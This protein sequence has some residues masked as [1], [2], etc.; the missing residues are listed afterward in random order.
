MTFFM[1][2]A[3]AHVTRNVV[4]ST[5]PSFRFSGRVWEQDEVWVCGLDVRQAKESAWT[6]YT[7]GC[8]PL[9][10]KFVV[11]Y[12]N[13]NFTLGIGMSFLLPRGLGT[14]LRAYALLHR[15]CVTVYFQQCNHAKCVLS[16][17]EDGEDLQDP[18]LVIGV[19]VAAVGLHALH[20]DAGVLGSTGEY[21]TAHTADEAVQMKLELQWGNAHDSARS[22]WFLAAGTQL[23]CVVGFHGS[24]R[25]WAITGTTLVGP[26][27]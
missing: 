26:G 15:G 6:T 9:H 11:K 2:M 25:V 13:Q 12:G 4:Q 23:T 19:T 21:T 8:A 10:W 22:K 5:W 7:I 1:P 18:T 14:R 16:P 24:D 17:T 27:V 20:K 3:R